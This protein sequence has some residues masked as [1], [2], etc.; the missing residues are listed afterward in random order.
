MGLFTAVVAAG[1]ALLGGCATTARSLE[2][3]PL[4][5]VAVSPLRVQEMPIEGDTAEGE[6]M[7]G[8]LAA[9]ATAAAQRATLEQRLA[10][11]VVQAPGARVHQLSGELRMPVELPVEVRGS[12]A[13]FRKGTFVSAHLVLTDASGSEVAST[14]VALEWDDIRWTTGGPKLRR[15]RR[16]DL[17]LLDAARKAVE[18]GVRDLQR[19]AIAKATMFSS[20]SG[21]GAR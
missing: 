19:L 13:A 7:S 5:A 4:E 17:V 6:W 21:A 8:L 20:P 2:E 16:T 18:L 15:Q 11:R 9:Q 12:W 14:E 10:A 3:P 1:A